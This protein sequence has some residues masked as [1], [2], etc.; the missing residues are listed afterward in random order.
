MG[1]QA[2]LS[3]EVLHQVAERFKGLSEPSRLQIL[4]TLR[5]GEA[6]VTSLVERTDLTQANLS[7]HLRVLLQLGF[8]ERRKEGLHAWYRLADQ[9]VLQLCDLVCGRLERQLEARQK[10]LAGRPR[11]SGRGRSR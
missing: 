5:Q 7:R 9:D 8:V 2:V 1:S 10:E 6:T 11:L 4:Q 3:A